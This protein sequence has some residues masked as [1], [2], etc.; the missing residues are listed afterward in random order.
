MTSVFTP[1]LYHNEVRE[2]NTG[3]NIHLISNITMSLMGFQGNMVILKLPVLPQFRAL[4]GL[5]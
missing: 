4:T 2:F 1:S 3:I 5:K